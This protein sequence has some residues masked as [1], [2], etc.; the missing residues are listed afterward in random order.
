MLFFDEEEGE[1]PFARGSLNVGPERIDTVEAELRWDGA[2]GW[3]GTH[4][5]FFM[6]G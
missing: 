3:S 2:R 1:Y 5:V 6:A 4:G